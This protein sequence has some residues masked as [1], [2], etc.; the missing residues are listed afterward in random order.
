MTKLLKLEYYKNLNYKPFKVFTILYFAILIALLFIGLVDFDLFGATINLK[1]EGIYNFPEIWNFTTWI[2]GLLK[3]FLGLIIV[4][5]ISQEFSDRMFKQNTIDGLSRKEFIG[6]KLLTISIFTIISTIIVFAITMLLGYQ[7]S[8]TT[9]SA[10][11]FEEIFF[12]GNYF[13]KLFTFFC[14]LMFLSVLLRKSVF[15]FLAFFVLWIIESILSTVEVFMKVKGL[16][17]PQRNEVL[18]NDF[19]LSRLFPLESMSNLIPNPMV[20]LNMA[21]A[22]GLKY[23]FHY[24]TESLIVCL[25]W[26]AIFIFGSYWILRKRDW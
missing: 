19:F 4:F 6:S 15:V 23:E 25:V 12:I 8:N 16:Q 1:E 9:E 10:K 2:V 5:S 17:G 7:Y 11:V 18:Q 14:F 13:I 20:R 26:C 21:K 22:M 24:P 3:I